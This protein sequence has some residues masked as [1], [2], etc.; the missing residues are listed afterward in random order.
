M[1]QKGGYVSKKKGAKKGTKKKAVDTFSKKEWF[2][3][4]A[5]SQFDH[6]TAGKTLVTR[7]SAKQNLDKLLVGRCF[8]VNQADLQNT[9]DAFRKFKFIVSDVSSREVKSEFYSMNLTQ[10]KT[11][12][13]IKKWHTLIEGN[14]LAETSDGYTLRFFIMAISKRPEFYTKARCYIQSTKVKM[15]RKVMF[16]V[17]DEEVFGCDLDKLVKKL[18]VEKIGQNIMKKC[19]D[20]FPITGCFVKKVMV[21]KR[22]KAVKEIENVEERNYE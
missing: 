13:I 5:P 20:I 15:I 17:V 22:P 12:G 3:L 16:D 14:C 1:A 10:D 11:R 4:R 6:V 2:D 7:T 19:V 18:C 8:E 21:V 9:E